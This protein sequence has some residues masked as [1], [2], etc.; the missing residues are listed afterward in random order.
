ME[1]MQIKY[2]SEMK[3]QSSDDLPYNKQVL[4]RLLESGSSVGSVSVQK[5]IPEIIKL[6]L[7]RIK[8]L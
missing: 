3:S 4:N 8:Q 5:Q 1:Q 6:F 7:A 2:I